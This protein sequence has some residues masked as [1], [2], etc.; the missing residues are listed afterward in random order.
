MEKEL[1]FQATGYWNV[2]IRLLEH[3]GTNISYGQKTGPGRCVEQ[4]LIALR[5][6]MINQAWEV[7]CQ[8]RFPASFNKG[9]YCEPIARCPTDFYA[10]CWRK[11]FLFSKTNILLVSQENRLSSSSA[12]MTVGSCL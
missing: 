6:L 7:L 11:S 5:P 10:A 3:F 4:E 8:G 2:F 12:H 9:T 1:Q